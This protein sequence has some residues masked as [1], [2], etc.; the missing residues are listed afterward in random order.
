MSGTVGS[1]NGR[2]LLSNVPLES[3]SKLSEL[4]NH[5]L[6]G[7]SYIEIST[8]ITTP[9]HQS[10]P[11]IPNFRGDEILISDSRKEAS[12]RLA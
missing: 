7:Q 4:R 1:I 8:I 9:D 6:V 10:N 3:G 12:F 11:L 5:S 2:K